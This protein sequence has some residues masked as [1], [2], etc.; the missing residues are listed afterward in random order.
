MLQ[1]YGTEDFRKKSSSWTTCI[2]LQLFRFIIAQLLSAKKILSPTNSY[3]YL[4]TK[5]YFLAQIAKVLLNNSSSQY[6][7]PFVWHTMKSDRMK[8]RGTYVVVDRDTLASDIENTISNLIRTSSESPLP[9]WHDTSVNDCWKWILKSK[10]RCR[11]MSLYKT[12]RSIPYPLNANH[13]TDTINFGL[14]L[15]FKITATCLFYKD[16]ILT[17]DKFKRADVDG[18]WNIISGIDMSIT[19]TG[20]YDLQQSYVYTL[21][22][23]RKEFSKC[24]TLFLKKVTLENFYRINDLTSKNISFNK[25]MKSLKD[26]TTTNPPYAIDVQFVVEF[27]MICALI[28]NADSYPATNCSQKIAMMN[29]YDK[30]RKNVDRLI[31]YRH[32]WKLNKRSSPQVN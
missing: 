7:A 19:D 12:L 5:D 20:I 6:N 16:P 30:A 14:F 3:S 17:Y 25:K 8:D 1:M 13:V 27:K 22:S 15:M 4:L 21:W 26:D 2:Y 9:I 11:H 28:N 31:D 18:V 23:E 24:F 32:R 10:I 29:R